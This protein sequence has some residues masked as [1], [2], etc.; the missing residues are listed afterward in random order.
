LPSLMKVM[1]LLPSFRSC[2]WRLL[3][4]FSYRA[5][6]DLSVLSVEMAEMGFKFAEVCWLFFY[7]MSCFI[8]VSFCWFVCD[9]L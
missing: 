4:H 5:E 3:L 9:V 6:S 2:S 7:F 8:P 1:L